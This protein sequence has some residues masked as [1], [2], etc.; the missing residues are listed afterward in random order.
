M[1][2]D[3]INIAE[4][5]SLGDMTT[6]TDVGRWAEDANGR[7]RAAAM[8]LYV[9]RGFDETTVADI[10]AKAGVS[11]RTFFRHFADKREV[12]FAG[13]S[14]LQDALVKALRGAPPESTPMQAVAAALDVAGEFL[15]GNREH[16]RRRQAIISSHADLLEREL[17]KMSTLAAALAEGLRGRGVPEPD[18]TLAAEAGVVV[19][20]VSFGRWV[21]P[22]EGEGH[23]AT[24]KQMMRADLA[25]LNQ[26]AGQGSMSTPT[27]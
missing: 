24:L 2:L 19:F 14:E 4:A 27:A 20:R 11:A 9:E 7:L 26:V 13:S 18:A 1:S 5:M 6:L 3:D 21:G 15:G 22:D 17:I 10:A 8:Q 23:G 25:R 16:S 12:L